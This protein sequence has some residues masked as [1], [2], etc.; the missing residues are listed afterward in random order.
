MEA[1]DDTNITNDMNP[2][3]HKLIAIRNIGNVQ[4]TKKVFVIYTIKVLKN[5]RKKNHA[6]PC[7]QEI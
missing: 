5:S 3:Y 1:N 4:V 2:I 6:K 7:G